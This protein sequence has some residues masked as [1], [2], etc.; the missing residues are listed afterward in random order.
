[1]K[2]IFIVLLLFAVA[3]ILWA[4]V[5]Q[6]IGPIP[7]V[8]KHEL[9]HVSV[10]ALTKTVRSLSENVTPR[11]IRHPRRLAEVGAFIERL[12]A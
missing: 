7:D 5:T 10:E 8:T 1:M 2:K 12:S 9:P 4:L 3:G 6:P 11:S